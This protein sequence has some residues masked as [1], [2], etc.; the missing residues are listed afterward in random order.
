MMA[1][2]HWLRPW[3]LLAL[4]PLFTF[5]WWRMQSNSQA[6]DWQRVCDAH[7]LP[8]L[9][10]NEST[11]PPARL[12]WRVILT[13]TLA[14]VALA[15]PVWQRLPQPVYQKQTALVLILDLSLSMEAADLKPSRLNRARL[16]ITDL[17]KRRREGTTALIT[18]AGEP[19]VVTPLTSDVETITAHLQA[20]TTEIM[21]A[22][23]SRPDLAIALAEKLFEQAGLSEGE[24]LLI[25]DGDIPPAT[26]DAARRF[27]SL[28]RRLS[29]LAVGTLE[30]SPIQ[31][32]QGGFLQD[33]GGGIV[34]SRLDEAPL[35]EL[36][37]IGGGVYARMQTDESDLDTLFAAKTTQHLAESAK[38]TE[39][40]ADVWQEEG[41]WLLLLVLPLAA[42][43]F[44]RGVLVWLLSLG[45]A[46]S[47]LALDWDGLWQRPDQRA[48]EKL[49]SGDPN[50]AASTF[51]DPAWK[52][53]ALYRAGRFEESIQA[54]ESVDSADGWY[55][56]GNALARMNRLQESVQAYDEALKRNPQ[57]AD[58]RFNQEL[59]KKQLTEQKP[60]PNQQD[61]DKEDKDSSKES[62]KGQEQ[63][64]S[65]SQSKEQD[66]P[67]PKQSET[68]K[69]KENQS[70]ENKEKEA[71]TQTEKT[72]KESQLA[73]EQWLRR[74]PDD[75]G[76]LLRRKFLYQY[77]RQR[78][79]TQEANPW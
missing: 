34:I 68:E 40:T 13:A 24:A 57:H 48:A 22:Q 31:N 41:P 43:G 50:G 12:S 21:P 53:A 17:L 73:D 70:D 3:W 79:T 16:K 69:E 37:R 76:G 78:Q 59:V 2:F 49:A 47:A 75:P 5:W 25:T 58:A 14:I 6:S 38:K 1:S 39:M 20:M 66:Q 45:F 9:L 26:L 29:V 56:K 46:Q 27:Q 23:G 63:K 44:R 32:K 28:G 60:P 77:Q 74:I 11:N 65:E 36:V 35:Q 8:F 71:M 15:G 55:N 52:A 10:R 33:A 30:G 42:T 61:K 67:E 72:E 51:N 4:L 64:S 62:E 19:F 7:L 18:Y 54:L